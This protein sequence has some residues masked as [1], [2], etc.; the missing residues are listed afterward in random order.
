MIKTKY[1]S[2]FELE[3]DSPPLSTHCPLVPS[4]EMW[5]CFQICK[6]Q[7]QPEDCYLE[8][9]RKHYIGMNARESHCWKVNIGSGKG[10][11]PSGNK[12]LPE[13]ALTTR[14]L[15]PYHGITRPRICARHFQNGV[16]EPYRTNWNMIIEDITTFLCINHQICIKF[17]F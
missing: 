15:M 7:T 14:S 12:P 6:F 13:P 17:I 5:L 10:F 2:D 9:S 4:E 16:L 8:H 11:M 3:N 1:R